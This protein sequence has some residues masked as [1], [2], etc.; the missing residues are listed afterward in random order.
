MN[1]VSEREADCNKVTTI[2]SMFFVI[3][4]P[5]GGTILT[6]HVMRKIDYTEIY[7]P[8]MHAAE[9]LPLTQY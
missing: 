8:V 5:C 3:P 9:V 1:F 6:R 7:Q 2:M 4:V